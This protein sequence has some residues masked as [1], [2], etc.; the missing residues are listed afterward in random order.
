MSVSLNSDTD[1]KQLAE[2]FDTFNIVSSQLEASYSSLEGRMAELRAQLA[3]AR[4]Q[5]RAVTADNVVLERRIS[6]ILEA[7]PGGVIVVDHNGR[8]V[9]ANRR[10]RSW[11]PDLEPG[12]DWAQHSSELFKAEFSEHGDLVLQ[13]GQRFIVTQ[14]QGAG[15]EHII[16]LTDV[17][18]QRQVDEV[19]ARHRRLAGFGE[20]LAT[21]A[22]QMRTP[23]TAA[24]LYASNAGDRGCTASQ[25]DNF[26]DKAIRCLRDLEKLIDDM[27]TFARGNTSRGEQV[28]DVA[29][30]LAEVDTTVSPLRSAG[31]KLSISSSEPNLYV[32]GNRRVLASAIE[33][34]VVNALQSAGPQAV[35]LVSSDVR[36]TSMTNQSRSATADAKLHFVENSVNTN[37]DRTVCIDVKDNGPGIPESDETRIFEPFYSGRSG[38][39][40]LGL[41]AARSI[42]RAH[43]GD[44]RLRHN[45]DGGAC[46]SISLPLLDGKPVPTP[47]AKGTLQ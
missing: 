24:L 47:D 38:G 46:F 27:L 2:A 15:N 19:L 42:V 45:S 9:N 3:N 34:L 6:G 18:E 35:V 14:E 36:A 4:E 26:L 10:A 22:H 20:M 12:L 5:R 43:R 16:L 30:L 32:R 39:T 11:L 7:L 21:V 41:A 28:I 17:T 44:L 37:S 8:L 23:I 29:Q 13:N 33:N 1:L 25:R 40:G 31:Q